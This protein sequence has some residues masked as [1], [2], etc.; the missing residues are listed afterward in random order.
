MSLW[1]TSTFPILNMFLCIP[2]LCLYYMLLAKQK[3]NLLLV[4]T[5]LAEV[6]KTQRNNGS[7]EARSI[8]RLTPSDTI[9][10]SSLNF[11]TPCQTHSSNLKRQY[12]IR[13]LFCFMVNFKWIKRSHYLHNYQMEKCSS[14]AV[15]NNCKKDKYVSIFFSPKSPY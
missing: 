6:V 11:A 1:F 7:S 9:P 10:S 12:S 14:S 4:L 15:P 13:N 3:L 5:P 8:K 2:M